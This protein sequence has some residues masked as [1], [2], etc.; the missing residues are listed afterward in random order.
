[1]PLPSLTNPFSFRTKNDY[2]TTAPNINHPAVK[3]HDKY[4]A[5]AHMVQNIHKTE[6]KA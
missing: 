4:K 3:T 2:L 6:V 1:M 5:F